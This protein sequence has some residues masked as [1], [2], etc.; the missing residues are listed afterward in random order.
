MPQSH[1][2]ERKTL[3]RFGE[4][5]RNLRKKRGFSQEELAA[6]AEIDRTY[7]GGVERGERNL[8]L[9]NVAKIAKALGVTSAQLCEGID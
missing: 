1:A 7:M 4:N 3:G 9:L 6:E 8:G 2:E 5:V